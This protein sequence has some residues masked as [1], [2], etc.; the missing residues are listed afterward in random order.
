ML[1]YQKMIKLNNYSLIQSNLYKFVEQSHSLS[2]SKFSPGY[3]INECMDKAVSHEANLVR[4]IITSI[5][6]YFRNNSFLFL[7]LLR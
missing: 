1:C 6:Y 3:T 7:R 5:P 4:I 2:C